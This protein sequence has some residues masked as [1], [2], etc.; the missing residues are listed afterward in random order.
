MGTSECTITNDLDIVHTTAWHVSQRGH[1][2][3][4]PGQGEDALTSSC[5]LRGGY[6]DG[7]GRMILRK[8][9]EDGTAVSGDRLLWSV[10][11]VV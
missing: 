7:E 3:Q 2:K 8:G 4:V 11:P 1:S 5:E 10:I 6:R 9:G